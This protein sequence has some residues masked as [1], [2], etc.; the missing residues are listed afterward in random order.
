MER[1]QFGGNRDDHHQSWEVRGWARV[2]GPSMFWEG[3]SRGKEEFLGREVGVELCLLF[4][5]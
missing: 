3:G 4:R 5:M 1:V 2:G